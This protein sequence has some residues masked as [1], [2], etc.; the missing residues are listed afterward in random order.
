MTEGSGHLCSMCGYKESGSPA[1]TASGAAGGGLA[2]AGQ[3]PRCTFVNASKDTQCAMCG[4]SL[5]SKKRAG[6]PGKARKSVR[7]EKDS[8]A[9][10]SA[11]IKA[12]Q[13]AL[14]ELSSCVK[15]HRYTRGSPIPV[16]A[17]R[18]FSACPPRDAKSE[19]SKLSISYGD[20]SKLLSSYSEIRAMRDRTGSTPVIQF[21]LSTLTSGLPLFRDKPETNR[22]VVAAIGYVLAKTR[23]EK[24]APRRKRLA[25][26]LA[27]AFT[28]CQAVQ[29]R[30][31]YGMFARL[32]NVELSF[33]Q[34][35]FRA[36]SRFKHR[37]LDNTVVALLGARGAD[38]HARSSAHV[39]V[40]EDTGVEVDGYAA[41]KMDK[42][43]GRFPFTRERKKIVD[44]FL[45][46]FSAHEFL[47]EMMA[48]VNQPAGED[49]KGK[50]ASST[51]IFDLDKLYRWAGEQDSSVFDKY[52]IFYDEENAAD[53]SRPQPKAERSVAPY[54]SE[55]IARSILRVLG[56]TT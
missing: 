9:S 26:E 32:A 14:S 4:G 13:A 15:K 19:V 50:G 20:A 8:K 51:R 42:D 10:L 1:E 18:A 55:K 16:F 28:A 41:A 43:R 52:A 2:Q 29:Q 53:Y 40:Y 39:I 6:S 11:R 27:E 46:Y 5:K 7:A 24:N 34:Q 12:T 37:A 44:L 33:P 36:L 3:C 23:A 54:L 25:L 17:E 47:Q 30:V 21:I 35:V 31:I 48:D 45:K 56:V 22:E 38:P 49:G